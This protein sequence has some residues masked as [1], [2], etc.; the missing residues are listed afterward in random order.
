MYSKKIHAGHMGIVKCRERARQGVWW[1][2]LS[3][4]LQELVKNCEECCKAQEQVVESLHPSPLPDL[5]FQKVGT[6]LF[7][8]DKKIYLLIVDYYSLEIAKLTGTTAVEVINHTKSI[9]ARH[10]IPEI[11]ISNNGPQYASAAYTQFS[12]EYGFSHITSS[13]LYLKGM[14]KRSVLLRQLNSF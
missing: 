8:W 10:G 13:P 3:N 7:D 6:D 12:Q 11:V 2:G 4:Q 5:P 14:A 1:P 9:F